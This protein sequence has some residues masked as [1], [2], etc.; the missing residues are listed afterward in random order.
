MDP[1]P[2]STLSKGSTTI[3]E[4]P[5]ATDLTLLPSQHERKNS[6]TI[7]RRHSFHASPSP[8]TSIIDLP[9]M[10][11][12]LV[13]QLDLDLNYG[14]EV[15]EN[16]STVVENIKLESNSKDADEAQAVKEDFIGSNSTLERDYFSL[17]EGGS[18]GNTTFLPG[19]INYDERRL[20]KCKFFSAQKV[21]SYFD[22]NILAVSKKVTN[23]YTGYRVSDSLSIIGMKILKVVKVSYS[24]RT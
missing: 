8:S 2:L 18:T 13:L 4:S 12:P 5:S 11:S 10:N 6:K 17:A 16:V 21:S 23:I 14:D 7:K 20:G 19:T 24:A 9:P 22:L 15:V 1:L 3:L